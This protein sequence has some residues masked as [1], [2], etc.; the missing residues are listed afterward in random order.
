MIYYDILE[1]YTSYNSWSHL[2]IKE[3]V[4]HTHNYCALNF[5]QIAITG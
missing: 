4:K 3:A 5:Q 2:P 1:P